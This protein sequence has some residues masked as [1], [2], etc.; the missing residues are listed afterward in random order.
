MKDE[1]VSTDGTTVKLP[2]PLGV[3]VAGLET[4]DTY[5]LAIARFQMARI[6]GNGV[7]LLGQRS[8]D[9]TGAATAMGSVKSSMC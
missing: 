8:K 4:L 2:K 9:D 3:I 1:H 7:N 6:E 5:S